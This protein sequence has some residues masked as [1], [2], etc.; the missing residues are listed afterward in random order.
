[1]NLISSLMRESDTLNG[2]TS[3]KSCSVSPTSVMREPDSLNQT[4]RENF[5][6]YPFSIPIP[7]HTGCATFGGA[8]RVQFQRLHP[9]KLHSEPGCLAAKR[10]TLSSN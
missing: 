9:T 8:K 2:R 10:R 7:R 3:S 1:M 6:P 5:R 4:L